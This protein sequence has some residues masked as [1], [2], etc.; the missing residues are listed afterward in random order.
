MSAWRVPVWMAVVAAALYLALCLL[1]FVR[2]RDLVYFPQATRVDAAGTPFALDRGDAVLRG[3]V[4]HPGQ[5]DAVLYF[6]G[7]AEAVEHN[8]GDFSCW[9]PGHSIYLVAY[10]GFGA[11]D[12]RPSEPVLVADAVAL[13]D[14]IQVRHPEGRIA[15]V[16]RSLGSGVAVQ[17]AARRAVDRLVLVTPFDSLAAV[18]ATHYPWLP[19]RW[20]LRDRYDSLSALPRH[21]GPLLVLRAGRDTVV[22]PRHTDALVASREPDVEVLTFARADHIDIHLQPGYGE[23]LARFI[24]EGR[25]VMSSR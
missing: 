4:V 20:L 21:R 16:G 8:A 3:R 5:R 15:V 10:R 17:L 9:L 22:P 19:V 23:T 11:S 25:G 2:Q 6:G 24:G 1:M 18:G 12:G 7:N 13:Y 14:E